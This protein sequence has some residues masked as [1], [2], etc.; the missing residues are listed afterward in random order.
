MKKH[1]I[2][3]VA[4]IAA[5]SAVSCQKENS[6][7]QLPATKGPDFTAY[8]EGATKTVFGEISGSQQSSLWSGE[9]T[10]WI[11]DASNNAKNSSWKKQYKATLE[12][13]ASKAIFTEA[14]NEAALGAGPYFAVYPSSNYYATWDGATEAPTLG[15]IKLDAEQ[16]AVKGGYDPKNHVSVSY[17]TTTSLQFKN[18]ISFLKIEV[19][20]GCSEVCFFGKGSENLA[21]TFEVAWNEGNPSVNVTS[22]LTYAKI[23]G[24]TEAGTYYLAVLPNTF[25]NGFTLEAIFDGVKYQRTYSKS[26]TLNRNTVLDLGT[27]AKW[28]PVTTNN[29][30]IA[31]DFNDWSTTANPM[32]TYKDSEGNWWFRL[33]Y[34]PLYYNGI[35]YTTSFKFVRNGSDWYGIQGTD[36]LADNTVYSGLMSDRNNIYAATDGT[37]SVFLSVDENRFKIVEMDKPQVQTLYLKVGVNNDHWK[38][39]YYGAYFFNGSASVQW[40]AMNKVEGEAKLYS[41]TVPEGGYKKVI[42]APMKTEECSWPN[43]NNAQTAN[44]LIPLEGGK[45]IFNQ[46]ENIWE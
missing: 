10:L 28:K 11:M 38:T 37:Y 3:I 22:G 44:L 41:C 7:V 29:W 30:Y 21:G 45:T 42:F 12:T 27:A 36:K 14:Y 34:V 24:I 2:S 23:T 18:V 31:G 13:P 46:D 35:N 43:F 19:P 20:A 17:S 16:T 5:L 15:S 40:V 39:G 25:T 6:E 33:D 9:E 4:A 1:F 26:F 8:V 32:T